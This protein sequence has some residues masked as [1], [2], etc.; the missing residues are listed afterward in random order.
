MSSAR[1]LDKKVILITGGT[2]GIGESAAHLFAQ[3]GASVVLSGRRNDRGESIAEEIRSKGGQAR[4]VRADVAREEDVDAL[5]RESVAA[6]GRI[7]AAF[8]NAGTEGSFPSLT[9]STVRDFD[10]VVTTN[11]RGTWLSLRAEVRQMLAQGTG[12]AIVN[13][14]SWLAVGGFEGSALYSAT[15]GGIDAM[16]RSL[17]VGFAEQGIRINTIQ[18]GYIVTDMFRRFLDPADKVAGRPFLYVTPAR[19]YGRAD[20]AAA[21]AA[22]LCSDASSYVTGQTIGVDGGLTV[23]GNR[24]DMK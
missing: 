8:N 24:P 3:Q 10:D 16:S 12:G 20:E 1:P 17:A 22:W 15:K 9:S 19:R 18:P 2:S 5:V 14:S 23:P 7:D 13:T 6:F 4:F 11:L 21:L